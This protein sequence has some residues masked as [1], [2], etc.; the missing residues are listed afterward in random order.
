VSTPDSDVDQA[1][2]DP[3]A[4]AASLASGVPARHGIMNDVFLL[5][6]AGIA[7]KRWS[8]LEAGSHGADRELAALRWCR[9]HGFAAAPR[10]LLVTGDLLAMDLLPGTAFP[11]AWEAATAAEEERLGR[12]AGEV[13]AALHRLPCPDSKGPLAW[14]AP[15]T[16]W[17]D[18]VVAHG[19]AMARHLADVGALGP[20]VAAR[21]VRRLGADR[22]GAP[23]PRL[24][25]CHRDYGGANLLAREGSVVGLVDW[26]WACIADV[27]LDLARNEWLPRVGRSARLWRTAAQR[28]TFYGGYGQVRPEVVAVVEPYGALSA[29]EYLVVRVALGSTIEC[30]PLV[31][32]LGAY[33]A[34]RRRGR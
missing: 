33:A 5:P 22:A 27:R 20:D 28:D 11:E 16:T 26:E 10:P 6:E 14:P 32:H 9:R 23:A 30:G 4:L 8:R 25:L 2:L 7:V 15:G 19:E 31:G 21:V 3:A 29:L 17:W 18:G 24:G 12:S 1:G 34:G 13:L